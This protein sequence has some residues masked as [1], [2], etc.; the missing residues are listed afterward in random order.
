M[1][2]RNHSIPNLLKVNLKVL[3]L[4]F[5]V[6]LLANSCG[7][8]RKIPKDQYLVNK[9]K[10][11]HEPKALESQLYNLVEEKPNRRIF[12]I[13]RFHLRRYYFTTKWNKRIKR[14]KIKGEPP[15]LYSE[16]ATKRSAQKMQMLL[17]NEG[18]FNA[19]V[20]PQVR[21]GWRRNAK[22]IY[23][24]NAGKPYTILN[25][26]KFDI[27]DSTVSELVAKDR[28]NSHLQPGTN[29]SSVQI[30]AEQ[31]RLVAMLKNN[32]YFHFSQ[33]FVHF[34][35]DSTNKNH[36]T[37][38]SVR[39]NNPKGQKEHPKVY[40]NTF[41]VNPNFSFK[42][43]SKGDTVE[44]G[45]KFYVLG[46]ENNPINNIIYSYVY[47]KS[48]QEYNAATMQQSLKKLR[49][50]QQFKYIDLKYGVDTIAP[51]SHLLNVYFNLIPY[52]R[53]RFNTQLE[54][55]T[56]EEQDEIR[57][58]SDYTRLYGLAGSMSI[59]DINFLNSSIQAELALSGAAEIT[60]LLQPLNLYNGELGITNSFYFPKPFL[61]QLIPDHL[62]RNINQSQLR[63]K[64]FRETNP[65][66]R[67]TTGTVNLGYAYKKGKF[68][69]IVSPVEFSLVGAKLVG[70]TFKAT[71]ENSNNLYLK[72]LFDN[73]VI[74]A[75]RWMAY[76]NSK[77][78]SGKR[79]YW[80]IQLTVFELAGNTLYSLGALTNAAA[81]GGDEQTFKYSPLGL[82]SFQ[83][84]KGD[85]DIRF[86]QPTFF[87]HEF[88]YR[89]YLGLVIPYGNTPNAIPFQKRY[90]SGGSNGIRGWA[91][92][93]L[94]PG[95][96]DD[97]D[98]DEL[99]F[100][101]SGDIKLEFNFEY[102]FE[103][104]DVLNM[105]V[106]MDAGNVWN[107]P[108]NNVDVAGGDFAFNTFYKQLAVAGGV[109][110]RFDFT[111]FVFRLDLGL[112]LRDPSAPDGE[113]WMPDK[114]YA[115]FKLFQ[116][117]QLNFGIGYPF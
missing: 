28:V 110:T 95:T 39:I 43:K 20:E 63:W 58:Q 93:N 79:S 23:V 32:G 36:R 64:V 30:S 12:G 75:T 113:K 94:G 81:T 18:Y 74:S 69:H 85:Y 73:H 82:N 54:I 99:I 29:F 26:L 114:Y 109:G 60:Q 61:N 104:S 8:H 21:Y 51:D 105:A 5:V 37:S 108:R 98:E 4:A 90:F 100:L 92:R 107:H 106:F 83:Y 78:I 3:P 27:K 42:E 53:Y 49:A 40:F 55:N 56:S 86:H 62:E 48:G 35:I 38:V 117:P 31:T 97:A 52:S 50:L 88:V 19:K 102:R 91:I 45:N 17:K 77:T 111:Y 33:D 103:L 115:P 72:N 89:S 34:D 24:V 80:D 87:G 57:L 70:D 15:S 16:A 96:Y 101:Q 1:I 10:L 47:V 66:Y 67:R 41:W 44:M 14:V 25:P 116:T 9:V 22:V 71:I 13:T 6:M 59:T 68:T 76:Y 7:L 112:P 2:L 84:F 65:D 46:T 11:K